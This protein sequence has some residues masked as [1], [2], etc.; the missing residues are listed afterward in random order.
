[1]YYLTWQIKEQITGNEFPNLTIMIVDKYDKYEPY[2]Y[3]RLSLKCSL[4]I[5][6]NTHE[7]CRWMDRRNSSS[8]VH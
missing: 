6:Y 5:R 7:V 2:I 8:H 1:M 4:D 3:M